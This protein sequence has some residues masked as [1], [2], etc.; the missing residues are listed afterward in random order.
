M[1]PVASLIARVE[2]RRRNSSGDLRGRCRPVP[3]ARCNRA[4]GPGFCERP[5]AL[6]CILRE[7]AP[8]SYDL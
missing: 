7:R 5:R 1:T 4:F 8:N 2:P 3:P 6:C